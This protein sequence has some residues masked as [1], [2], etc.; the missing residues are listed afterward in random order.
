[1]GILTDVEKRYGTAT[2]HTSGEWAMTMNRDHE[3]MEF[4]FPRMKHG[5]GFVH[6]IPTCENSHKDMRRESMKHHHTGNHKM[7]HKMK[8]HGK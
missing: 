1:M 7:E 8:H 4:E 2:H 5:D 6:H 3:G